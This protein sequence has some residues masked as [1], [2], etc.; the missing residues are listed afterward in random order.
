[1]HEN[2]RMPFHPPLYPRPMAPPYKTKLEMCLLVAN[3]DRYFHHFLRP[4]TCCQQNDVE[5]RCLIGG[6]LYAMLGDELM[7]STPRSSKLRFPG[8][9]QEYMHSHFSLSANRL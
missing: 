2:A 3:C 9:V 5:R 8:D 6:L 7:I 4:R 1:M